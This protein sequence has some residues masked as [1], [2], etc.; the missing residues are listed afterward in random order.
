MVRRVATQTR[1]ARRAERDDMNYAASINL[2][3]WWTI[4]DEKAERVIGLCAE[5]PA[6]CAAPDE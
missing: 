4:V 1:R 6:I 3:A 5:P 2:H